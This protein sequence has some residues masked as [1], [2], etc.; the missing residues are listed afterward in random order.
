MLTEVEAAKRLLYARRL[1]RILEARTKEQEEDVADARRAGAAIS[2]LGPYR[3][4][5]SGLL[6]NSPSPN[7]F[8][9]RERAGLGSASSGPWPASTGSEGDGNNRREERQRR[10]RRRRRRRSAEKWDASSNVLGGS[11]H[12]PGETLR[13]SREG[14]GWV[15]SEKFPWSEKEREEV[16]EG[17]VSEGEDSEGDGDRLE[18]KS[19]TIMEA[20][21]M[22]MEDVDESVKVSECW[23]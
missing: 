14:E 4:A 7:V 23:R 9:G 10:R 1:Q 3:P 2:A 6:T 13:V 21:E 5:T 22:I 16:W 17:L 19:R 12:A 8:G 18:E 20:A 11:V 15:G